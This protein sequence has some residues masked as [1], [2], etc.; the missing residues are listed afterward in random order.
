MVDRIEGNTIHNR[1]VTLIEMVDRVKV[2]SQNKMTDVDA[3]IFVRNANYFDYRNR[4]D[5]VVYD[6]FHSY[7]LQRVLDKAV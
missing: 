7:M 4:E 5:M 2:D 6:N 1:V 3:Y